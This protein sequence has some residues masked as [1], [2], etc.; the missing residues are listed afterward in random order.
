MSEWLKLMLEEIG[1][2]KREAKEAEEE[3]QR[4]EQEVDEDISAPSNQSK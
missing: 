2:K 1:R 3:A 4:R